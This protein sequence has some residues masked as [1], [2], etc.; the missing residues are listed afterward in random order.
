MDEEVRVRL[1]KNGEVIG[2]V[3]TSL[4]GVRFRVICEDRKVRVCRIPGR[5]KKRLYIKPGA[6]VLV[7]PWEI[8]GDERGD[9]IYKYRPVQVSWLRNHGKLTVV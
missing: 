1:P 8:Q 2:Y 6:V 9:I 7:K 5:F 3:E 4:G